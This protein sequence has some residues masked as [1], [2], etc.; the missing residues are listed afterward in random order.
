[1]IKLRIT[2]VGK[3]K[4]PYYRDA[5]AEYV[6]RINKFGRLE[7]VETA[8]GRDDGNPKTL[9]EVEETSIIKNCKGKVVLL[10]INGDNI[11][12]VGI[13][14]LID[15]YL[16]SGAAEITFV[17][18][19]SRGVS[20]RVK[21]VADKKISFGKVTYPHQLMRVVLAEQLYRAL[22]IINNTGYHK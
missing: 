9:K 2:A 21:E 15:S 20:D 19:G 10:D 17:I 1:M 3:I 7:I 14:G 12:S 22:T 18:G 5:I 4:E 16:T 8:E 6:K 11:D 13:A